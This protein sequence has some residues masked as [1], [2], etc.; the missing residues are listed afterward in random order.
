MSQSSPRRGAGIVLVKRP[1]ESIR[2]RANVFIRERAG[3]EGQRAAQHLFGECALFFRR[4]VF[5]S[6]QQGLGLATHTQS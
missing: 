4:Q 5:E 1:E 6:L 2:S 3:I